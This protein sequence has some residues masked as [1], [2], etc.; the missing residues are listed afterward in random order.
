[1]TIRTACAANIHVVDGFALACCN[2]QLTT[3]G[4]YN[5][6]IHSPW[7]V[8]LNIMHTLQNFGFVMLANSLV[9]GKYEW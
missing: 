3:T 6:D 8:M 5:T 2:L 7:L 1:M 9:W 4:N